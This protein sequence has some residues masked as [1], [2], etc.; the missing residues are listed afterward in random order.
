MK[1]GEAILRPMH[2]VLLQITHNVCCLNYFILAA[3]LVHIQIILASHKYQEMTKNE[4][5]KA[6]RFLLEI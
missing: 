5:I 1:T 4:K 3:I 2:Y 6:A